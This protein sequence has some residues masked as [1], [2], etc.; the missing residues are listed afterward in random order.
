MILLGGGQEEF[1]W[2]GYA[3]SRLEQQFGPWLGNVVLGIIWVCWHI[4]LWF[5]PG[6]SQTF[7]NFGGFM[8]LTVGYSFI[9]SWIRRLSGDRPFSGLYVHGVANAFIPFMPILDMH[10]NMPQP[11]FWIWVSLTFIVGVLVM[12]FRKFPA[13]SPQ[14]GTRRP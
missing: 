13:S 11:R 5:I 3:L 2:R 9:F 4:P 14:P 8:L 6:T 12:A 1:G 7:M 10:A